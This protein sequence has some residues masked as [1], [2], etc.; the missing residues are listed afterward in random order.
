M[1]SE[2]FGAAD[3][4]VGSFIV[5]GTLEHFFGDQ[6]VVQPVYRSQESS[7]SFISHESKYK[8]AFVFDLPRIGFTGLSKEVGGRDADVTASLDYQGLE[9]DYGFTL[10][11]VKFWHN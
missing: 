4:G 3:I 2:S 9:S 11:L 10:Q 8:R 5:T 6:S 7:L 1:Q